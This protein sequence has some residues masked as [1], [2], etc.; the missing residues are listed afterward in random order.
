MLFKVSVTKRN[1]LGATLLFAR[2]R[3]KDSSKR[4]MG[5]Y[6]GWKLKID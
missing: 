5:I 4:L 6:Q 2:F 3:F 1:L